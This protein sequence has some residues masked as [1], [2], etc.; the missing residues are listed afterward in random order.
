ML[1]VWKRY[2]H[3]FHCSQ[4]PTFP[5]FSFLESL[6]SYPSLLPFRPQG[7]TCRSVLS[8]PPS[9]SSQTL[10]ILF[11][12]CCCRHFFHHFG[13]TAYVP[14][15]ISPASLPTSL[16]FCSYSFWRYRSTSSLI[17]TAVSLSH[18]RFQLCE[19]SISFIPFTLFPGRGETL[20]F[21]Q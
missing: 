18:Q 19:L 10:F 5:F 8:F 13:N 17:F 7:S 6:V 11:Q 1:T 3:S 14:L 21:P 2:L 4:N 16:L 15:A 12:N 20:L 9:G